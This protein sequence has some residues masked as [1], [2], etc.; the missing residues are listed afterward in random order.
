MENWIHS[1]VL[2]AQPKA[3][4]EQ[5]LY[6]RDAGSN[7]LPSFS[8]IKGCGL[9]SWVPHQSPGSSKGRGQARAT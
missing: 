6:V 4:F 9:L 7:C 3:Q 2:N 1:K 8:S 5:G